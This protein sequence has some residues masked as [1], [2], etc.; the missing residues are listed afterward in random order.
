MKNPA[1]YN[2]NVCRTKVKF[3]TE[4]AAEK[5]AAEVSIIKGEVMIAYQCRGTNHY[6]IA[7][8]NIHERRGIGHNF[9]LCAWCG[10]PVRNDQRRHHRCKI[11]ESEE[12]IHEQP[13][14]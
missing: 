4:E 14:W 10:K 7:H 5:R 11:Y 1:F 13:A 8:K 9:Y 3:D 2:Y 6:H 12:D